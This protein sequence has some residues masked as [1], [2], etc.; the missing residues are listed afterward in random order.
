L[1]SIPKGESSS[2]PPCP[3]A[4]VSSGSPTSPPAAAYSR[5]ARTSRRYSQS[6]PM[7]CQ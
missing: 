5:S 7:K 2:I 4:R 1:D 3:M 6:T